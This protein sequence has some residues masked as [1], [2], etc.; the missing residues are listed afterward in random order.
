MKHITAFIA[1]LVGGIFFLIA[2]VFT[3]IQ[4]Y[5]LIY[6]ISGNFWTATLGLIMFEFAMIYWWAIFQYSA[7]GI[8]QLGLSALLT[9]IALIFVLTATALKLGAVDMQ[10]FGPATA[11][12]LVTGAVIANVVGKML[13]PLLS[14]KTM[15]DIWGRAIQGKWVMA[16]YASAERQSDV[17]VQR[18]TDSVGAQLFARAEKELMT[19]YGIISES[20]ALPANTIEGDYEE[21]EVTTAVFAAAPSNT[22]VTLAAE[23]DNPLA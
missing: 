8:P 4:T 18:L 5:S 13:F 19:K 12:L 20:K 2:L 11:N 3:G 1:K 6:D 22:P 10:A 15:E 21:G 16:A 17:H 9:V 14:Q 7:D 23:E